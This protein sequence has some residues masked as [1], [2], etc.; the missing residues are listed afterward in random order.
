MSKKNI[1]F[2]CKKKELEFI[3]AFLNVIYEY[4]A[5]REVGPELSLGVHHNLYLVC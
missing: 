2:I 3:R 5:G 4:K 1:S